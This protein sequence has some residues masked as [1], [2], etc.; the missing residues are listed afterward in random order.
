MAHYK[1]SRLGRGEVLA[2]IEAIRASELSPRGFLEAE[3]DRQVAVLCFYNLQAIYNA[4]RLGRGRQNTSMAKFLDGRA[5]QLRAIFGVSAPFKLNTDGARIPILEVAFGRYLWLHREGWLNSLAS[6]RISCDYPAELL[7]ATLRTESDA[8]P[9][10]RAIG[11]YLEARRAY[12]A[13]QRA[14]MRTVLNRVEA[15]FES[16]DLESNTREPKRSQSESLQA[17]CGL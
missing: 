8:L 10:A 16:L 4:K 2:L 14:F 12:E 15:E 1:E 13:S 11:E 7:G 9:A 3:S 6:G 17:R 5:H